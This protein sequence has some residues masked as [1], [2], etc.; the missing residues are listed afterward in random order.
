LLDIFFD[1]EAETTVKTNQILT[2][3]MHP[4]AMVALVLAL[5]GSNDVKHT[6]ET[7]VPRGSADI[8]GIAARRDLPA[9]GIGVPPG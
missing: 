2:S 4:M 5:F 1:D 6:T 3:F 7:N 8:Y 9:V